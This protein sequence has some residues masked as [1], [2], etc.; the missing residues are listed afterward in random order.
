MAPGKFFTKINDF[1]MRLLR[2]LTEFQAILIDF[3]FAT[4]P[5]PSH[6][7]RGEMGGNLISAP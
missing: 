7:G 1:S 2:D 5:I 4:H 3:I 6:G